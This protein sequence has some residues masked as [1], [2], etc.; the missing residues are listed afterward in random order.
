MPDAAAD[1]TSYK[2]PATSIQLMHT[3]LATNED[4]PAQIA[5]VGCRRP[6]ADGKASLSGAVELFFFFFF[7][8]SCIL[9]PGRR[10]SKPVV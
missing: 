7:S 8:V 3:F 9:P 1:A 4:G 5:W 10:S 6:I 2:L